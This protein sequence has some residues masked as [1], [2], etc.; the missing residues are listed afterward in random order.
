MANETPLNLTSDMLQC[1]EQRSEVEKLA[2]R[3]FTRMT[4]GSD[5]CSLM[6]LAKESASK[7]V[8][9]KAAEDVMA[10]AALLKNGGA[11]SSDMFN[12]RVNAL[13]KAL[14]EMFADHGMRMSEATNYYVAGADMADYFAKWAREQ[15][16]Q[17]SLAR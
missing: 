14:G 6:D 15:Q 13:G 5:L 9:R 16:A 4:L 10:H 8:A 12:E 1:R 7:K 2:A 3:R 17:P 11:Q